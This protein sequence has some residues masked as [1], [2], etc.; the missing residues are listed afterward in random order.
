LWFETNANKDLIVDND[1][2]DKE[3]DDDND[4]QPGDDDSIAKYLIKSGEKFLHSSFALSSLLLNMFSN[5]QPTQ[6]NDSSIKNNITSQTTDSVIKFTPL[7]VSNFRIKKRK[8]SQTRSPSKHSITSTTSSLITYSILNQTEQ[9]T[10]LSFTQTSPAPQLVNTNEYADTTNKSSSKLNTTDCYYQINLMFQPVILTSPGWYQNLTYPAN[11]ECIWEVKLISNYS[12]RPKI[13]IKI[14]HLE[15]EE[16]TF[17]CTYDYLEIKESHKLCGLIVNKEIVIPS[18]STVLIFKSDDNYEDKG[19]N[20]EVSSEITECASEIKANNSG[21]IASPGFPNNYPDSFECWTLINAAHFGKEN[22]AITLTFDLIDLE[23]DDHCIYDFVEVLEVD[24]KDDKQ[25]KLLGKFCGSFT[26]EK[27]NKPGLTLT[28]I[29]ESSQSSSLFKNSLQVQSS[30]PYLLV[31]FKSDDL[32]N[33][34]GFKST[35]HVEH[36]LKQADS[37]TCEGMLNKVTRTL[38]SPNY[39]NNYPPDINCSL[40]IKAPTKDHLIVLIFESFTMELD[41]NCTFDRLEIYEEEND[42]EEDETSSTLATL[43]PS[44]TLCGRRSAKFK[45]HSKSSRI[46]IHFYSDSFAEYSGF[47][48]KVNFVTNLNLNVTKSSSPLK[49]EI[50]PKNASVILGSSHLLICKTRL[51]DSNYNIS[52]FKDDDLITNGISDNGTSLLIS[53]FTESAV[54]RYTCKIGSHLFNAWL[55]LKPSSFCKITFRKK[56]QNLVVT[57]SE[58]AF[59]ECSAKPLTFLNNFLFSLS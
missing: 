33:A 14:N 47:L 59:F 15:I 3:E 58:H 34:K 25:G 23:E 41:S 31:H 27:S 39:P 12:T 28:S 22:V 30:K 4:N 26:C 5:Q 9:L 1:D 37:F 42:A 43:K 29:F 57:E 36:F 54:G 49:I 32:L 40:V 50:V 45:Y 21:V 10:D 11:L 38:S 24:G 55:T 20:L 16:D 17:N 44:K 56:P 46:R 35:Y 18:K 51:E 52:W 19:F 13:K 6:L 48:A 53:E 8:K 7:K 2:D